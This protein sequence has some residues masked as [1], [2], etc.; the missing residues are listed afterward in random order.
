MTVYTD[1]EHSIASARSLTAM[2]VEL[3]RIRKLGKRG[4]L[5]P[6]HQDL[7]WLPRSAVVAAISSLDAYVHAVV[8][9][10]L[11]HVLRSNPVPAPLCVAMAEILPIKNGDGFREALPVITSANAEAELTNRFNEK[12]LAFNSY[13][14]PEKVQGAYAL[15][16]HSGV[17]DTVAATW[18]GPNT[19]A[20]DLKRYL[21]SYVK[22]RNQIAHE[23]D[24]EASG[25]VRPMQ[26]AYANGCTSFIE[27][28]VARLNRIVFEP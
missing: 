8:L 24:R 14:A 25:D 4:R 17:F 27:N 16:G 5:P 19:S 7:L 12:V 15:I 21:A 18:P 22:R 11:P 10:R 20:D 2:Y 6:E 23:G 3:R 9:G 26:P 13:Q 1:F 28:L